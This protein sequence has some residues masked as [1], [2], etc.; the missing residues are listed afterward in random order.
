MP[1]CG[2]AHPVPGHLAPRL[3]PTVH[4][5]ASGLQLTV[6]LR[7]QSISVACFQAR[8]GTGQGP[9]PCQPGT[10]VGSSWGWGP[11]PCADFQVGGAQCIPARAC[12]TSPSKVESNLPDQPQAWGK[13]G[14]KTGRLPGGGGLRCWAETW[15]LQTLQATPPRQQRV[16]SSHGGGGAS[17]A[18]RAPE[19][20]ARPRGAPP[21]PPP[22]APG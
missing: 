19:L 15:A 14:G 16:S 17:P 8:L 21:E 6:L 2:C 4:A 18:P 1:G 9:N 11:C 10:L 20:T 22:P 3:H 5:Q 13:G 7:I 12:W